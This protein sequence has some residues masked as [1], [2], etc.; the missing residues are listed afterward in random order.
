V[1]GLRAAAGAVAAAGVLAGAAWLWHAD[2][3]AYAQRRVDALAEAVRAEADRDLEEKLRLGL[4]REAAMGAAVSRLEAALG[5]MG[6]A[7][8]VY[9]A[10]AADGDR[11]ADGLR[12]TVS[13]S[14]RDEVG[15]DPG[16]ACHA[17]ELRSELLAGLL[18]EGQGLC[19]GVAE[20]AW[21]LER[22]VLEGDLG[23]RRD[24]AVIRA[25]QEAL[26]AQRLGAAQ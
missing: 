9:K 13:A 2:R 8:D 3:E 12:R 24:A 25:L 10:I 18:H 23:A 1:V 15:P 11:I 21:V 6:R 26:E 16:S 19:A 20:Q 4:A 7:K 22:V 14:R 5:D 17:Q